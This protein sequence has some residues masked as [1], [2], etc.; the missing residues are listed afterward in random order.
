MLL[1]EIFD[2]DIEIGIITNT[3]TKFVCNAD[4][5]N[6]NYVFDSILLD[7]NNV[8]V[9]YLKHFE[10]EDDIHKTDIL[11]ST[12]WD[13]VFGVKTEHDRMYS[14][15]YTK[16]YNATSVIS[17]VKK[18]I[19]VLQKEKHVKWIAFNCMGK[20]QQ[21]YM[22]LFKSMLPNAKVYTS[23]SN[24]NVNYSLIKIGG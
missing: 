14:F 13:V 1:T 4:I 23:K 18:C 5:D 20:R 21:L 16:K 10:K 9:E 6:T 22:K 12:V 19:R 2:T 8:K 15:N 24:Y 11:D 3:N 17:F 7:N